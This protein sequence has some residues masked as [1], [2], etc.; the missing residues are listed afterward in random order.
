MT[1]VNVDAQAFLDS[2]FALLA[3]E[4]GWPDGDCAIGKMARLWLECTTRET[5]TLMGFEVGFAWRCDPDLAES[6]LVKSGLADALPEG[7]GLRIRGTTGRTDWLGKLRKN[8]KY[9]KLG[10]RPRV[11]ETKPMR[12]IET[13]PIDKPDGFKKITPLTLT[14]APTLALTDVCS[15][16]EASASAIAHAAIAKLNELTGRSFRADSKPVK[17]DAAKLAKLRHTPAEAVA[18]VE[19]KVREWRSDPKMAKALKPSV[20]LRPSNF[21]KYLAE[22]VESPQTGQGYVARRNRIL[23]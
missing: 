1:R 10:G 23:E 8:G 9:G 20:L 4:M 3:S 22:D 12:V 16:A 13:K 17:A 14:L 15:E 6:A 11:N 21:V 7:G 5:E 18:V 2:R 19:A